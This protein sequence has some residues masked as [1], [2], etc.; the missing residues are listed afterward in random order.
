MNRSRVIRR[1][2]AWTMVAV[3]VLSI[4]VWNVTLDRLP[5]E[6]R[7]ATAA[8]GG[9]Y[10]QVAEALAPHIQKKTDRGVAL[11]QTEGTGDNRAHL[12]DGC[13]GCAGPALPRLRPEQT[14]QAD[15][16]LVCQPGWRGHRVLR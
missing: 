1:A 9:L 16:L 11:Q 8:P 7:I 5:P 13:I 10:Y 15:V 12:L 6:I 3:F 2:V 4:V 14:A